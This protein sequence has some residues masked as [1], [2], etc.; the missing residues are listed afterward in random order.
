[1]LKKSWLVKLASDRP[2]I[3]EKNVKIGTKEEA[4]WNKIKL[5][6]EMELEQN[7]REI[8]I[9]ERIVKLAEEMIEKEKK[10]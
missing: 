9:G 6:A 2:K 1:M 7:K 3:S 4:A 10:Q 8:I 5:G